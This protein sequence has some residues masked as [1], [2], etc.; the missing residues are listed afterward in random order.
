MKKT[1]RE[2]KSPPHRNGRGVGGRASR[3]RQ[4]GAASSAATGFSRRAFLRRASEGESV[5][6]DADFGVASAGVVG[7][8][9]AAE[10]VYLF[11]VGGR[12]ILEHRG[13]YR[14]VYFDAVHR[15]D[16]PFHALLDS[17]PD[18]MVLRIE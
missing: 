7:T 1:T 18:K 4:K 10:T 8:L 2:N 17:F 3:R 12:R 5:A 15:F 9:Y 13:L 6:G 16:D 14:L 11:G